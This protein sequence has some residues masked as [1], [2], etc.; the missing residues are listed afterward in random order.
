MIEVGLTRL[1]IVA[2]PYAICGMMDGMV[3]VM[4][5][6]GYSILPMLVS[7]LGACGLRVLWILTIFQVPQFHT[8]EGL[9]ISYPITWTVT[10]LAHIG[11]YFLVRRHL[12][13]RLGVTFKET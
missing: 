13:L 5:G 10:L 3:G 11:S 9:Y 2:G 12:K 7:L 8:V 6:L 1:K 4:R